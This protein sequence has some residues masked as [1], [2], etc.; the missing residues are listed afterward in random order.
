MNNNDILATVAFIEWVENNKNNVNS[1]INVSFIEKTKALS[2]QLNELSPTINDFLKTN[3]F[4]STPEG[5]INILISIFC[6][7]GDNIEKFAYRRHQQ[8][9]QIRNE[10]LSFVINK[11]DNNHQA[12]LN[13]PT[14]FKCVILQNDKSNVAKELIIEY[15]DELNKVLND[16]LDIFYSKAEWELSGEDTLKSMPGF[17]VI[18]SDIPCIFVWKNSQVGEVI[19]IDGLNAMG[20]YRMLKHIAYTIK[21]HG[22]T[23]TVRSIANAC[24]AQYRRIKED[25]LNVNPYWAPKE[26]RSDI[27]KWRILTPLMWAIIGSAFGAVIGALISIFIKFVS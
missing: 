17:N 7:Q 2:N 24:Q 27:I 8:Q 5:I 26:S 3:D 10:Q 22:N 12:R 25:N 1:N 4:D 21:T 23:I 19:P 16:Y 20:I 11:A 6:M 13:N 14:R 18:E 9:A 15:Q